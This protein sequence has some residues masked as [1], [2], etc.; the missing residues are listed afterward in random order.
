MQVETERVQQHGPDLADEPPAG[1]AAAGRAAQCNAPKSAR[2]GWHVNVEVS[3]NCTA[4]VKYLYYYTRQLLILVISNDLY[5]LMV[6][7]SC[8][9]L[10]G[11]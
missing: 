9:V 11:A 2:G 5:H 3:A 7:Y 8:T 10:F 1:S 4:N 6:Q